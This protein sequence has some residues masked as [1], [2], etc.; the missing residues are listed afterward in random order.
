M[1]SRI[2]DAFAFIM[3]P[4]DKALWYVLTFPTANVTWVFDATTSLWHQ[5]SSYGVGRFKGATHCF[6]NTRHYIGSDTDGT[7]YRMEATAFKD[8][9]DPIERIATGTHVSNNQNQVF[10]HSLEVLFDAGVG[11]ATGQGSDPQA[12]LRWSD[13]GGYTY[14]NSHWRS[15]GKI[16]EYRN[17]AVWRRLGR[18]RHRVYELTVTDPVNAVVV[19]LY[20]QVSSGV[21]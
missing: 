19:G 20:A 9:T 6:F 13:D 16:G 7:L 21:D 2:D 8:G 11:L 17:R 14:G 10:W 4:N 3:K 18:S 15:I 12:M 5:W 1:Y